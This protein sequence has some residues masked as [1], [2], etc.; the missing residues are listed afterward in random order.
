MV[1]TLNPRF[2]LV[3]RSPTSLQLGVAQ[4]VVILTDVSVAA[5]RMLAALAVGVSE[6]GLMMIGRSAGAEVAEVDALIARLAPALTPAAPEAAPP[7]VL[8]VGSGLT[9]P[10]LMLDQL[11]AVLA[12]NN[13]QVRI[14]HDAATVLV[15]DAAGAPGSEIS[16]DLAIAIGHYVLAPTLRGVWLR[17]DIPHLPVIFSDT[18]VELGPIIEPG[19]GPCLYC[20]ERHRIDADEA[21]PAISSQLW[22]RRSLL[23]SA[24]VVGEVVAAIARMA[25]MRLAQPHPQRV[26]SAP[27]PE[28]LAPT[29]ALVS[30]R[31]E[32]VSATVEIDAITGERFNREWSIHPECGCTGLA[33]VG[34]R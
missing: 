16:C 2:P 14:A 30:A 31:A 13:I 27:S 6:P 26:G 20:I 3:W 8:V 32:L 9:G 28:A 11:T 17:R 15:H 24:A 34:S 10:S 7:T 25:V 23:E 29:G 5:E 4:P 1:L 18:R 12:G 19:Y 22:G 33:V 21:W